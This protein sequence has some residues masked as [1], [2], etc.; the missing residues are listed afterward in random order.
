MI[1]K[2][3]MTRAEVIGEQGFISSL[4]VKLNDRFQANITKGTGRVINQI[5]KQE[6]KTNQQPRQEGKPEKE[7]SRIQTDT[8]PG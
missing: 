3:Q 1:S 8:K 7:K 2:L 4:A 6:S 5:D